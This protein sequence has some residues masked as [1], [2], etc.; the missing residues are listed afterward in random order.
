MI[1]ELILIIIIMYYQK[2]ISFRISLQGKEDSGTGIP[3]IFRGLVV[4]ILGLYSKDIM[5]RGVPGK[6]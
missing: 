1:F 3:R 6:F 2:I 5:M 4:N